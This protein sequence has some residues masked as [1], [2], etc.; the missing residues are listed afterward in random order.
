MVRGGAKL[1]AQDVV[2]ALQTGA[3]ETSRHGVQ[4]LI[5][6]EGLEHEIRSP[7]AQRLDRRI[8]VRICGYEDGFGEAADAALLREPVH[9]ML[10]RH[11]V[12]EDQHIEMLRVQLAVGFL[13]VGGGLDMPA[14]R[15]QRAQEE[16]SHARFIV[17]G[18]YGCLRQQRAEF[19]GAAGGVVRA[20]FIK[21]L[22][23]VL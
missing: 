3:V 17:D 12:I 7:R 21:L 14:S 15:P 8:Q 11:D 16:V 10:S 13:G 4:K 23:C 1:V 22:H 5:G 18:K 6:P 2:F 19:R 9:A 20:S